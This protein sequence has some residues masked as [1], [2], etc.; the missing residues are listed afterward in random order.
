M[1]SRD[2]SRVDWFVTT[3]KKRGRRMQEVGF[4]ARSVVGGG[5]ESELPGF[6]VCATGWLLSPIT[7]PGN[8]RRQPNCKRWKEP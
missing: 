2:I 5:K 8:F 6:E 7:G 4:G 3:E 1:Q